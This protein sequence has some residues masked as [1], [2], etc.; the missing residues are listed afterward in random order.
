MPPPLRKTPSS[1][2]KNLEIGAF[3]VF[4]ALGFGAVGML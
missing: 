2:L 1:P 4:F 3:P